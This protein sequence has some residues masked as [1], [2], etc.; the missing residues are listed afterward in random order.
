MDPLRV[1]LTT[2]RLLL[3]TWSAED[4]EVLLSLSRDPEV[5]RYFP[6]P[7]TRKRRTNLATAP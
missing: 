3:C 7:A 4:A 5:M 1:L 6:G 2:D